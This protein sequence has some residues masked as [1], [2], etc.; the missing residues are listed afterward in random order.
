MAALPHR[1]EQRIP[2]G[3]H[4]GQ[5][6]A[7][8]HGHAPRAPVRSAW[9]SSRRRSARARAALA[10]RHQ[11][12]ILAI[13]RHFAR[14]AGAVERHAG[15]AQRHR[16]E[17][18][19][20]KSSTAELSTKACPA[21]GPGRLRAS[22]QADPLL[23]PQARDLAFQRGALRPFAPDAQVP[24]GKARRQFGIDVDQQIELLVRH[25]PPIASSSR[26]PP[27]RCATSGASSRAQARDWESPPAA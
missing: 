8:A 9:S 14:T 15:Q 17:Q 20:R 2:F 1:V 7:L 23:Q 13:T 22:R 3:Q 5:G 10:C 24:I 12:R 6:I 16:F 21:P 27:S 11:Q 18:H 19:V 26:G 25:Q 4:A